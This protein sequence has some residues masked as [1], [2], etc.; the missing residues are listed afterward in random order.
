VYTQRSEQAKELEHDRLVCGRIV[1][2]ALTKV[3]H[4]LRPITIVDLVVLGSRGRA[5]SAIVGVGQAQHG[6]PLL[7]LL[8]SALGSDQRVR[9]AVDDLHA[10]P[11]ARVPGVGVADVRGPLVGGML[12]ALGA[13]LVAAHGRGGG[14]AAGEAGEGDARVCGAGLE[15]LRVRAHHDVG[16]HGARGGAHDEDLV[17]VAVELAEREVDHADDAG[18][19][20]RAAVRQGAGVVDVPAVAVLGGLRVDDNEAVVIRIGRELVV[21]EKLPGRAAARVKLGNSGSV[22]DLALPTSSRQNLQPQ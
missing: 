17:L 7:Q 15:D 16:H 20:A 6:R 5:D 14:V 13:R 11:L 22:T 19:V 18:R 10:R 21:S 9:Q 4:Q 8:V 2:H 3:S 1:P 12:Q